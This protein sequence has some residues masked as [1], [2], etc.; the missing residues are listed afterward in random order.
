MKRFAIALVAAF[1][2]VVG[3]DEVIGPVRAADPRI[4]A[5][6]NA[7]KTCTFPTNSILGPELKVLR[8]LEKY[9][10]RVV[11]WNMPKT[12]ADKV[13]SYFNTMIKPVS[14]YEADRIFMVFSGN[15]VYLHLVKKA[16]VYFATRMGT[17][18]WLE[19]Y[20]MA[21]GKVFKLPARKNDA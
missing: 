20:E 5:Q 19:M 7:W 1:L 11:V 13:L 17:K 3:V 15:T 16:C 8:L 12:E 2:F 14:N 18:R 10:D 4:T 6:E 21:T 9:K